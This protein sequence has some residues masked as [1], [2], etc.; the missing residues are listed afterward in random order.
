M[1][2]FT[3][4]FRRSEFEAL[5]IEDLVFDEEGLVVS[6]D[7]SKTNQLGQAEEKGIFYSPDPALCPI[8]A[9]QAWLRVFGRT[10]GCV[11]ISLRKN[12]HLTT[13]RITTK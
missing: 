12:H 1:L 4:A 8:C 11:F 9:L 5:N 3:G 7:K 6:L 10:E 13:R 2:E